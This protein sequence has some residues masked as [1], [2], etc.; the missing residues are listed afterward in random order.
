MSILSVHDIT[1]SK[2]KW[3][4]YFFFVLFCVSSY[5]EGHQS[6]HI[7]LCNVGGQSLNIT[8]SQGHVMYKVNH[9][10]LYTRSCDVKRGRLILHI[11]SCDVKGRLTSHIW[12]CYVTWYIRALGVNSH[13]TIT[14]KVM[15][16]WRSINKYY[17]IIRSCDATVNHQ[18][19]LQTRDVSPPSFL[20]INRKNNKND[21]INL[22][23]TLSHLITFA[24]N[25]LTL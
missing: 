23:W 25:L 20:I 14:Y 18:V 6:L 10:T 12:Y 17:I 2:V 15:L 9:Q 3:I 22:T 4:T 13:Q 21:K 8:S 24:F 5:A 7:R 1:P 19:S 11:R 16:R